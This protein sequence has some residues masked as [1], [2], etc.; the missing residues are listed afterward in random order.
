M[1][2]R[3]QYSGEPANMGQFSQPQVS[4]TANYNNLINALWYPPNSGTNDVRPWDANG[5]RRPAPTATTTQ[6]PPRA[7]A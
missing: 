6:T 3:P 7:T 2:S 1:F 5:C 4:L